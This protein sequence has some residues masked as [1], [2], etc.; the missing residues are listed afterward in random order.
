MLSDSYYF[1]S[2]YHAVKSIYAPSPKQKKNYQITAYRKRPLPCM[3]LS[4]LLVVVV[5][6]LSPCC[7]S[8]KVWCTGSPST[9][10]Y[11]HLFPIFLLLFYK[12][13]EK[14][15]SPTNI[16]CAG[17]CAMP[18]NLCGFIF[19]PNTSKP[20]LF[21]VLF[22]YKSEH[23]EKKNIQYCFE[24]NMSQYVL[25]AHLNWKVLSPWHVVGKCLF[26]FN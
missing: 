20:P 15:H 11:P 26:W 16:K 13:M 22:T 6:T 7:L 3:R 9:L 21:S 10:T 18:T 19:L 8:L 25:K 1:W 2:F 5:I 12:D 24:L 23:S 4:L 14:Q 17:L